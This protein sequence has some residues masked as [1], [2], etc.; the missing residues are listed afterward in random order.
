MA[1][2]TRRFTSAAIALPFLFLVMSGLARAIPINL[3]TVDT[4]SGG[5]VT[6]HCSLSDA[7]KAANTGVAQNACPA[8]NGID[9][10]I[11]FVVTGTIF[12]DVGNVLLVSDAN[13]SIVG[14][15]L[16]CSGSGP[17]G[18]TISGN[19]NPETS[20]GIVLTEPP[21][22]PVTSTVLTLKNLT[23]EEGFAVHGGAIYVNG[24]DLEIDDCLFVNNAAEDFITAHGG[25]GGAIYINSAGTVD[26]INSTFYNN[27]AIAGSVAPTGSVGGAIAD[28]NNSATLKLT[29]VTIAGNSASAGGGYAA[30]TSPLVKGTIFDANTPQNCA[31]VGINDQGHN[32]DSGNSCMVNTGVGSLKNTDPLLETLANN[33]GPTETLAL[34]TSPTIS[35]AIDLIPL[36]DC[37]DQSS[38]TPQP[39]GTDQRLF[40]R[41]DPGNPNACDSGAY[42]AGALQPIV[43]NSE[44][45]QIARSSTA[46]SDQVNIGLTFTENGDPDC[47]LGV[48]GDEDA[49][50]DGINV[51]LFQGTCAGLPANGLITN[52][53]TFTVHTVNHQQYGTL[54][55]VNGYET[56]S[57]RMVALPA[58]VDGCSAY[59]LNL[60][61]AGLNT[62]SA[63]VNLPGGN[64]FALVLTDEEG[65]G[66]GC[67]DVTN[68]IV[69]SQIP[70]PSHSVRRGVRRQ[71]RR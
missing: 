31:T 54:F 53:D 59:T 7:V 47:D 6:G 25:K 40:A 15:S 19:S 70:T 51:A 67:F 11:T 30:M 44:R 17:C 41:P 1:G 13:L 38:P 3:I 71:T 49:L 9:D 35:P 16:G 48:G 8:G 29:N 28:M 26:I 20:G 36:A 2:S 32:I 65:D 56:I 22:Y 52:L 14:P 10:E 63:T 61:V 68:A 69:G 33:G 23:F 39:L 45:V 43:L 12:L 21:V 4:L 50:N 37:T 27:G 58:P 34:E 64:P 60:E 5:S 57:A 55:Q 42:E 62:N 24:T 18:I 66:A 46:N